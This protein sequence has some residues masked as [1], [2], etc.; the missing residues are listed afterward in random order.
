[1]DDDEYYTHELPQPARDLR[2]KQNKRRNLLAWALA[3]FLVVLLIIGTL[4]IVYTL[5]FL[6]ERILTCRRS[7]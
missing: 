1:M 3:I 6:A 4:A 7:R 5:F 2:M